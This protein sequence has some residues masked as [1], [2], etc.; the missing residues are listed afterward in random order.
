MDFNNLSI[1]KDF[2][3]DWYALFSPYYITFLIIGCFVSPLI[4]LIVFSFKSCFKNWRLKSKCED[5]DS[6][7]PL[8]QKEANKKIVSIQFDYAE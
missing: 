7:N 8:V 4:G 6:E 2:T 5:N 3:R 1:F